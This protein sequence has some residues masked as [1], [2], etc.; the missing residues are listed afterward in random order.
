M[1]N[2]TYGDEDYWVYKENTTKGRTTS[3]RKSLRE[4]FLDTYCLSKHRLY[5]KKKLKR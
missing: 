1:V 2:E 3:C 5:Q 4:S